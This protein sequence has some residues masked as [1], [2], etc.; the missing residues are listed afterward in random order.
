MS[1]SFKLEMNDKLSFLDVEYK[2]GMIYTLAY[3]CFKICPIRQNF[4]KNLIS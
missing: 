1:F 2:V 3:R 4:M